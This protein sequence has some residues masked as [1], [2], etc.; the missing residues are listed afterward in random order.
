MKGEMRKA[1]WALGEVVVF[2]GFEQNPMCSK[3]KHN[4]VESTITALSLVT[5]KLL[6]EFATRSRERL[7]FCPLLFT[8]AEW[9]L[10]T[11]KGK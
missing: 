6:I 5:S 7:L 2:V 10:N 3:R 11:P 9:T 8:L 1:R 4:L